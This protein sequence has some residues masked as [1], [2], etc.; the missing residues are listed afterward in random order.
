MPNTSFA[1]LR[2][3]TL[4]ALLLCSVSVAAKPALEEVVVT[5]QK[6]QESLQDTPIAL[7]VFN[8]GALEREGISNVGDL[9]NNVPAL[10]IE[11]FPINSTQLRI[12]IRGIG[13]IDAQL[14]QDP[15]VGV[16]IDGAYIARSSG[17]ATDITDLQRIEVLRGPQGTLYGRNST[18]GA[19]NLI[20][21]RPNPDAL[22]FKQ[23]V[24][25]GNLGLFSSKTSL[26]LPLWQGAAAKLAYL[27]KTKNGHIENNGAPNQYGD[28][29]D[30]ETL[31]YRL[32][33]GWDVN[34]WIRVDYGY[35]YAE[36]ESTNYTY[37]LVDAPSDIDTGDPTADA[38]NNIIRAEASKFYTY[39][40]YDKRPDSI[41]AV[42]PLLGSDTEIEGHQFS[43]Q[44]D[45]ADTL[46]IKYL[47]AKRDLF[48]GAAA[49]LGTG[50]SSDAFRL[51]N[52]AV[53]SFDFNSA[54]GQIS[55]RTFQYND[56]RAELTQQQFSHELQFTGS[57]FNDRL[58]Y[59]AGLYYFE[60]EA[61]EDNEEPHHQLTVPLNNP[62][63]IDVGGI[64]VPVTAAGLQV[65]TSQIPTIENTAKAVYTQ[66][67]WLPP[68]LEDRLAVTLGARHSEDSRK[69]TQSRILTTFA[70]LGATQ[71]ALDTGIL[72]RRDILDGYGDKDYADNS[73]SFTLEYRLS[74]DIN[75]Y[76]KRQEAYKSGG[77]NIR[78]DPSPEGQARFNEG[79][80]QEKVRSWELGTKAEFFD[81]RL[82]INS[83][84]FLTSFKDQQLNFA[85]PGSLTDTAVA[86][87]G[88]SALS[89]F[90]FDMTYLALENLILVLNYAYLEG[91][92]EPS[93]NP[94]N[95]ETSD[96]FSFNSAPRHAATAAADWTLYNGEMG[97][98]SLNI[99]YSFTDERDG[100]SL[101]SKRESDVQDDFDVI[102]A[103][104]G[105]YE[106]P[107]AG[108]DLSVA[109]WVKN[110][111]NNDY[112]INAIHHLPQADRAV[113]FG[114]PRTYGLEMIY[115]F[116]N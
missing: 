50:Q 110:L 28:Y 48:D 13:L 20:T 44:F 82:R 26:N 93:V 112:V 72:L 98:A 30:S 43:V 23:T 35:D 68:I 2:W 19:V 41:D 51:D 38:V 94:L 113:L 25:T 37:T 73:F 111:E 101:K 102:N 11:P 16:Y 46:Q 95:G 29:G 10:T 96:D 92:I 52:N 90:E 99:T 36:V 6:R 24:N 115:R 71:T 85:I 8:E 54:Q 114:E 12:Y 49:D 67:T 22:E 7:D 116:A 100:S 21:K 79:F 107:L 108:G 91:A 89:G 14:T 81:N 57:A 105:M 18:G 74:D 106:I 15:P 104:L 1:S 55:N 53:L 5:A 83:D 65:L 32:D 76:L 47:Y 9:A 64:A 45:V 75:L 61:V 80:D 66:L 88:T 84:V 78:E 59:I 40:G 56:R 77:F 17:L 69:A 86:N 42:V 27:D 87:A 4:L 39:P 31:G 3:S 70:V 34:E 103:R 62:L 63:G 60:E 33:F 58:D 109:A 97:R